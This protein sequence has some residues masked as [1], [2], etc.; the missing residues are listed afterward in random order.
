MAATTGWRDRPEHALQV[1]RVCAGN[2]SKH[3]CPA[4]LLALSL[5]LML[6]VC[7]CRCCCSVSNYALHHCKQPVL[8]LQVQ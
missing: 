4:G 5:M 6:R 1:E 8:V 3:S 2:S 7:C